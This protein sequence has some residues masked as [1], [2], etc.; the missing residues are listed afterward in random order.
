MI[1]VIF[2]YLPREDILTSFFA[3]LSTFK[4]LTERILS[5]F[6]L[7]TCGL[8]IGY[9]VISYAICS[10]WSSERILSDVVKNIDIKY[11]AI[12]YKVFLSQ[13]TA[14]TIIW[15]T[16]QWDLSIMFKPNNTTFNLFLYIFY[17]TL[18]NSRSRGSNIF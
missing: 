8:I 3:L 9:K 1:R 15:R 4:L 2:L 18:I 5:A 16:T 13:N 12:I 7:R 11:S 17:F 10:T 14:C 6:N